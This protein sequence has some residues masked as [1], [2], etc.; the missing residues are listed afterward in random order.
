MLTDKFETDL[1]E[2][3]FRQVQGV[4]PEMVARLR[5]HHYRPRGPRRFVVMRLAAVVALAGVVAAAAVLTQATQPTPR[6]A[7]LSW[8]LVSDI[9]QAWQVSQPPS[10][11]D[12]LSLTCPTASTCYAVVFPKPD[13]GS[14][15]SALSIEVT[16]DGGVT[17]QRADLPADVTQDSGQFGPIDCLSKDTCMTLVSSTSWKYEIAETTDGGQTWTTLPGPAPLSTE[18]GVMGGISCTSSISCVLIGSYAVGT[19]KVG[20]WDAEVTTD[21]GHTWSQDPMPASAGSGAQCFAGGNCITPG[22]YSIDGGRTWSQGS[23]P[24]GIQFVV[25]MSCGDSSHCVATAGRLSG[26]PRRN[27]QRPGAVSV[28]SQ[29]I[30]T[31]NGGQTWTQ[32]PGTGLSNSLGL[33]NCTTASTCWVAGA[34]GPATI[35]VP[36]RAPTTAPGRATTAGLDH[37]ARQSHQQPQPVLLESTGDQ[38]QTWQAAKLPARYGITAVG[39]V[40]CSATTS[41]FAI[42]QAANGLVLL[43][44]G[45]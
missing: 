11:S 33:V 36:G 14:M 9:G 45:S 19:S 6:P 35:T 40:S 1:R 25:S 4:P 30:V 13:S 2:A 37:P 3:L 27:R 10:L 38:G 22:A 21:G 18:F 39:N 17:W 23:L 29:V 44:Y 16:H 12:G 32:V 20:Q 5:G 41:C 8:R 31:A 42:A 28:R 15:P 7:T 34:A 26:T 43:S 24:S